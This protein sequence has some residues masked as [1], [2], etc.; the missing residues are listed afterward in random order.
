MP[1]SFLTIKEAAAFT[2]KAE[3]TVRRFVQK[4]VKGNGKRKRLLIKPSPQE[5]TQQQ[6]GASPAWRIN[7][8]LLQKQFL[9]EEQG[10]ELPEQNDPSA[11]QGSDSFQVV[12]V[13]Q[14]QNVSLE[15]QLGVKDEQITALTTLVRSLGDQL[16][17]R[18]REGNILMKGLQDRLALPETAAPVPSVLEVEHQASTPSKPKG[19]QTIPKQR[20]SKPS[21]PKRKQ[22]QKT[23]TAKSGFF[24]ALF[25]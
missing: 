19:S 4:I 9:S 13:L 10:S 23:E 6:G 5:L 11:S 24:R 22:K 12:K 25:R 21:K 1:E 16:N 15:K 8:K 7:K 3:I 17:E 2:G 18:L 14:T 20:R